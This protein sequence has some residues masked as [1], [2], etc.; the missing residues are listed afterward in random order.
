MAKIRKQFIDRHVVGIKKDKV[1]KPFC[2]HLGC[3]QPVFFSGEE[4]MSH[5]AEQFDELRLTNSGA[6]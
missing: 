5:Y 6:R 2:T 3:R 4:C 1:I